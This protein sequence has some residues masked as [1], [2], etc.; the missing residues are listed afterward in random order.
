MAMS[1]KFAIIWEWS[2]SILIH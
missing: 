2:W 1:D